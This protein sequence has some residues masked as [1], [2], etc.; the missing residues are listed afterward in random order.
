MK[1]MIRLN[2]ITLL[3]VAL[4]LGVLAAPVLAQS[5]A[6]YKITS[7]TI[8][9]GGQALGTSATYKIGGTA[10]QAEPAGGWSCAAACAYQFIQLRGLARAHRR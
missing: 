9:S 4:A 3:L 5:G 7:S 6:T 8:D 2:G 10:G 1:R